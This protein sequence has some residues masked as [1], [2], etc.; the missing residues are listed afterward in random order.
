M[1]SSVISTHQQL[2][3][4]ELLERSRRKEEEMSSFQDRV[5]DLEMNTRVALDHLESIPEKQCLMDNFKDLEESQRQ[6]EMLE[7]RYTKYKEIVWD[8]QHQLDE[9]KRRIQEYRDEKLDATSRSL[10]LAALS[11]SIKGPST[12][13]SSSLRSDTLSPHKRLTSSDLEDSLFNGAKPLAD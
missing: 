9:S 3:L 12:F 5:L 6:R 7:Q 4:S 13:L 2:C 8:L 1:E 10:R 11:S